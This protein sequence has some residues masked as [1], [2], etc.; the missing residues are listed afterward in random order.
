MD[1]GY[2]LGPSILWWSYAYCCLFLPSSTRYLL[3]TLQK[4]LSAD[5]DLANLYILLDRV[6]LHCVWTSQK[7]LDLL[8]DP[9]P[10]APPG[11][12]VVTDPGPG[13]FC[14]DAM[15]VII[16]PLAPKADI[17]QKTRWFQ[18]AMTSLNEVGITGVGNAGMRADDVS[19]LENMA[20]KGELSMRINVMLECAERNTFCP[21][22]IR[23]LRLLDSPDS[24]AADT[25]ILGGVKLFA[26]GALGSW[27]A[28]LLEPYSDKTETSGTM[29][30]NETELITVVQE[31]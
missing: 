13:V 2:R 12:V 8:S 21:E 11:G 30:I 5:P 28:A 10:E 9:L 31:V 25:L 26:D 14:D 22:E 23:N 16:D 20:E 7:V 15:D 6:D 3:T 18:S 1:Q 24:L 17:A 4:E 19:V 29:L 27:G